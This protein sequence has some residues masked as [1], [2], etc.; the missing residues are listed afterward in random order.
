MKP[1]CNN[2]E[3]PFSPF[4]DQN[5]N[6]SKLKTLSSALDIVINSEYPFQLIQSELACVQAQVTIFEQFGGK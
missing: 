6:A 3:V 4:T 5:S 2:C 1:A